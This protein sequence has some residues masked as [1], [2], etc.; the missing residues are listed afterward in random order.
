MQNVP[1]IVRERLKAAVPAVNHPD[2]EVLTAFAERSLPELERAV[3]L[4][5]MA[6]C[7][8][9]RDIVALA[10]PATESVQEVIIAAPSGWLT[11]PALRWGFVAAGVIAIA[12]L[13]ILQYQ[14]HSQ[15]S[16][17]AYKVSA[18]DAAGKVAKNESLPLPAAPAPVER[19][20]KIEAPSAPAFT[21]AVDT[22]NAAAD[23]K[24]STAR[25]EAAPAPASSPPAGAVIGG[26]SRLSHPARSPLPHGPLLANQWQQQNT[27]QQNMV[28][29]QAPVPASPVPFAKQQRAD[30][31]ISVNKRAPAV[32]E[33][34]QVSGAAPVIPT[35]DASLDA[36][37]VPSQS[38]ASPS[39]GENYAYAVGKAKPLP[40]A[41]PGQIGGYVIDPSG[42]VVSNARITI[43]PSMTGGTATAVTDSQGAWMIAGLPSGNYKARAEAPGFKTT[44][45]DLN[46]DANQPSLYSFTLSV[47]SVSETVEVASAQT[48]VQTEG[49]TIGG[50]I[51]NLKVNQAP[52]NG[53]NFTQ[54]AAVP[55]LLPR[56]TINSA[57]VLQRS[58]DQGK[59]WQAVDVNA[60]PASF[61]G[62][63]SLEVVAKA[64]RTKT[65]DAD[66]A[67]KRDAAPI[68]FRVLAATGAEVWAG[69]S[70]GALYHSQDAG[71]HWTRVVPA[72]AGAILTGDILSLN[73]AD[74]QHGTLSTSNAEVW[75]TSDDGQ[76]WQKQ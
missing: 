52:A 17:M 53:R 34:V 6:R 35:Q 58:F 39:S 55:A 59:S 63:T 13:G 43:T 3:V 70:V 33:S 73:F 16:M 72:S 21:D 67:L 76:T 50:P 22:T 5:H 27:P 30:A 1:K 75:T 14:R 51:T 38:G 49:A 19:R 20:D 31:D 66:K 36:S 54:M 9:C 18:P 37:Q 7:G 62:A 4:E 45:L 68:T 10:L 42:A 61:S 32:S 12:S 74:I 41:T 28:Q 47:G 48:Q 40:Q 57:G 23:E 24:K 8:D 25:S 69:G 64:S 2:A 60:S 26:G 71:S 29:N 44:V 65:K 15:P 46:Y 56:W 11:W